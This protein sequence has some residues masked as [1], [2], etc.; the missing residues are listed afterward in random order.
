MYEVYFYQDKN[1]KE[2]VKEYLLELEENKERSK[3]NG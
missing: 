2:P 3:E 1:G